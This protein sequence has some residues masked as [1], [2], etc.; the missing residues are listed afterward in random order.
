MPESKAWLGSLNDE[1]P[2]VQIEKQ[3]LEIANICG[4]ARKLLDSITDSKL[5]VGE[6]ASMVKEMHSLDRTAITWRNGP[7]WSFKTIHRSDLLLDADKI[8]QFPSV[9][10][11]HRD[12]WIAYEWN[13]H[14]T[15]RIVLHGQLLQCLNQLLSTTQEE[16]RADL[17]LLTRVSVGIIQTLADEILSTV[18]QSLGDVDHEGNVQVSSSAS[19]CRGVGAYLLLWPIKTVKGNKSTTAEQRK[20]AQ[21]VFERIRDYTGMKATLGELSSI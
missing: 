10:Q 13:Y 16:Y 17:E 9:I 18:P 12:T 1:L 5:E 19:K 11:L 7:N 21:C 15:A 6:V 2:E 20:S 4:R 3:N 14:R 8:A